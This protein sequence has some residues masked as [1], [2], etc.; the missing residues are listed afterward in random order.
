MATAILP[1]ESTPSRETGGDQVL[2]HVV[3]Y[4]IN[5]F[6]IQFPD[7][8]D[9]PIRKHLTVLQ[10]ASA[11]AIRA[12]AMF[13]NEPN[14]SHEDLINMLRGAEV[15]SGLASAFRNECEHQEARA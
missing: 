2:T 12:A 4:G 10:G 15:L 8:A 1:A 13:A 11:A 9:E 6:A 14:V 3:L 5:A 7:A